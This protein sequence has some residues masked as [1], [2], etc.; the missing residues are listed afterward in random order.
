MHIVLET[1][2]ITN[3]FHPKLQGHNDENVYIIFLKIIQGPLLYS[4]V[5][6][7][8]IKLFS[9]QTT[10]HVSNTHIFKICGYSLHPC[11]VVLSIYLHNANAVEVNKSLDWQRHRVLCGYKNHLIITVTSWFFKSPTT[12][13]LVQPPK[14]TY[15]VT[16]YG[17]EDL[18]QHWLW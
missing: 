8:L 7:I 13:L 4:H 9:P 2:C 18:G 10:T 17:D 14:S 16:S 1:F 12:R 15:L 3:R 6:S 11:S 5:L